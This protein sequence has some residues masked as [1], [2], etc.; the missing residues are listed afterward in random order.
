MIKVCLGR[1]RVRVGLVLWSTQGLITGKT[2]FAVL[3]GDVILKNRPQAQW[4][5]GKDCFSAWLFLP[6]QFFSIC[7]IV[8]V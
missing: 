6:L 2:L 4:P 5:V 8:R 3:G 1:V 7:Q